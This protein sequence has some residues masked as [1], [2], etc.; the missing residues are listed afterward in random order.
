MAKYLWCPRLR[1]YEQEHKRFL[2]HR[3]T[4]V[5]HPLKANVIS[6]LSPKSSNLLSSNP[7][8][9]SGTPRSATPADPLTIDR[10]GRNVDDA[11]MIDPLSV[12][13]IDDDP[14]ALSESQ[15]VNLDMSV[16]KGSGGIENFE[17]WS[18]K[19][20]AILSKYTTSEKLTIASSFFGEESG[21]SI[22]T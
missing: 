1:N 19:R 21:M 12:L 8:S 13:A 22:Y 11:D 4:T 2:L 5:D 14:L 16:T 20:A 7:T 6:S 15:P 3:Q 17:P 9:R 10:M 18:V